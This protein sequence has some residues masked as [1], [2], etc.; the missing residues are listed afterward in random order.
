MKLTRR[1]IL[2]IVWFVSLVGAGVLIAMFT[3]SWMLGLAT[4]LSVLGVSLGVP[5]MRAFTEFSK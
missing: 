1:Q 5:L 3:D 2:L 4:S